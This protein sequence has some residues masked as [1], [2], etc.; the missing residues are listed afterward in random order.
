MKNKLLLLLKT[1]IIDKYKLRKL[2]KK[3]VI[4][5]GILVIY[6][7]GCLV[8]TLGMFLTNLFKTLNEVGMEDYY[9]T[10]LFAMSSLF[11][12]A[13][14]I[15]SAKAGLFDNKDNDLLLALPIKRSDI[16]ASRLLLLTGYNFFIGLIFIIPGVVIYAKSVVLTPL[17]VISIILLTL[18]FSI[19][20]TILASLFGYLVATLTSKTN[21]KSMFELI[22]YTLFI[23]IYMFAVT[24]GN[25][26]ISTLIS[27]VE[28]L[29]ILLKSLF[30]PIFFIHK[31][32]ITGNILYI[33]GFILINLVWL[34]LFIYIFNKSYLRIISKLNS[35]KSKS[36]F[37]M[38]T[39]KTQ[40][41]KK[42]LLKKELSRYFSSAIYVFNTIFGVA[43]IAIG[44]VASLIYS[45]DKLIALVDMG[46]MSSFT[47]V[48]VL[49]LFV[50]SLTDTT[51]S[52]I[53]IERE[54]F[55]IMKMIPVE[56]K[57]IFASKLNKPIW[58]KVTC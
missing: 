35:H 2:T 45:P 41:V 46:E 23:F 24:S 53:S 9:I 1:Y 58:W 25:K 54:N 40:S 3:R 33:L 16:L 51:N 36:N 47:L 37:K 52:S 29:N 34:F 19:I 55:W 17:Y 28:V 50:I 43:F 26:I 22:F 38:Q 31:G 6:V 8:V 56:T 27:N 44:G 12:F 14:S 42:A 11:A 49:T 20:P 32:L 57:D 18:F 21:N 13:F 15:F 10:L 4:G 7:I 48:F 39:L 5:L 30:L